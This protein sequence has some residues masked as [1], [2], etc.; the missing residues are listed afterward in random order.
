M[1]TEVGGKCYKSK[2]KEKLSGRKIVFRRSFFNG[3]HHESRE[4]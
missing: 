3:N 4:E 1:R 2:R